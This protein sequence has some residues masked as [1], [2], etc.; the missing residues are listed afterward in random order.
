MKLHGVEVVKVDTFKFESQS[1]GCQGGI[2]DRGTAAR[3][4]NVYMIIVRP[5]KIY[6]LDL[7]AVT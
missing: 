2:G 6:G 4:K 7:F 5:V 3:L 1:K